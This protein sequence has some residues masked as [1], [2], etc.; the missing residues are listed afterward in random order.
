MCL[1]FHSSDLKDHRVCRIGTANRNGIRV[2][3]P[4]M[5]SAEHH[6]FTLVTV[7][8]T[9]GIF[10]DGSVMIPPSA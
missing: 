10:L 4:K 9:S 1:A 5:G 7:T 6:P 2:L 8:F 3:F